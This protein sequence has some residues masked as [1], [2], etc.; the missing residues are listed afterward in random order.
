MI[1]I[2]I[3]HE[4][5]HVINVAYSVIN[6]G[7]IFERIFTKGKQK[8]EQNSITTRDSDQKSTKETASVLSCAD[9]EPTEKAV[10][11]LQSDRLSS[12]KKIAR[13]HSPVLPSLPIKFIHSQPTLLE[14]DDS[15]DVNNADRSDQ[16]SITITVWHGDH[17]PNCQALSVE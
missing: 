2:R 13:I 14:S 17:C 9:L 6:S 10:G 3:T 15:K 1:E 5:N 12:P 4:F 11:Q 16:E 7:S 8:C